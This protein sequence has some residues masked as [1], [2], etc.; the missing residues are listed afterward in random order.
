MPAASSKIRRSDPPAAA[1]ISPTG[2]SPSRCAGSEMAQ[3]SIM[4]IRVQL[5]NA[6]TFALAKLL[7]SAMSE[8][9]GGVLAVVG[10]TSAS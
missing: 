6:S 4:L 2:T 8:I 9:R 10:S 5:R 1:S 3:P 7:S